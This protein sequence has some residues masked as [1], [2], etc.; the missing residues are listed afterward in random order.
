[1]EML[2]KSTYWRWRSMISYMDTQ[3]ARRSGWRD[4]PLEPRSPIAE[5]CVMRKTGGT[6]TVEPVAA[7][8][9]S[10][11]EALAAEEQRHLVAHKNKDARTYYAAIVTTAQLYLCNLDPSAISLKDG[12]IPE[13]ATFRPVPFV[14][15]TKQLSTIAAARVPLALRTCRLAGQ[16][17]LPNRRSGRFSSSRRASLS[18]FC[19]IFGRTSICSMRWSIPLKSPGALP[20]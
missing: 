18:D 2:G 10:A 17:R 14:R 6:Q 7:E 19:S 5:F 4:L 11:T 15:F 20:T 9:V 3:G 8:L 13:D 1:M 12:M 16:T